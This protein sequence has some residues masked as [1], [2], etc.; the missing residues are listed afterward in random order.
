MELKGGFLKPILDSCNHLRLWAAV[1]QKLCENK[2][3]SRADKIYGLP[4]RR[5]RKLISGFGFWSFRVFILLEHMCPKRSFV[6]PVIEGFLPKRKRRGELVFGFDLGGG[7][8]PPKP[9]S[10][11]ESIHMCSCHI[12]QFLNSHIQ[13]EEGGE[14]T[15]NM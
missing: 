15:V 8:P 12:L 7:I 14:M 11:K 2:H 4:R 6:K 9:S 1:I 10:L 5:S 13:D 3:S